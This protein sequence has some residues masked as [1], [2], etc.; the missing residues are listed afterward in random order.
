MEKTSK[1]GQHRDVCSLCQRNSRPRICQRLSKVFTGAEP[2]KV[3]W[4]SL[5]NIDIQKDWT[6]TVDI[7]VDPSKELRTVSLTG[8][9]AVG[10]SPEQQTSLLPGSQPLTT[11]VCVWHQNT[12][13]PA[14][15]PVEY[16]LSGHFLIAPQKRMEYKTLIYVVMSCH[17][18]SV[19]TDNFLQYIILLSY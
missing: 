4:V 2:G 18:R 8:W 15:L 13:I 9:E 1:D 3:Q 10:P 12:E 17:L 6:K 19:A 11:A 5:T 14:C 7:N 16:W